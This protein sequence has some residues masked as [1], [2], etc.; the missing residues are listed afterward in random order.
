MKLVLS[1]I[2]KIRIL[3]LIENTSTRAAEAG[4][5]RLPGLGHRPAEGYDTNNNNNN[6][7]NSNN[8]NYYYY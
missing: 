4:A 8:N 3:V 2:I 6:N 5:R 7:S 1:L